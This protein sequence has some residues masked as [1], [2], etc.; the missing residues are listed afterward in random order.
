MLSDD[1]QRFLL[2]RMVCASDRAACKATLL[3]M[4]TVGGWKGHNLNFKAA[5]EVITKDPVAFALHVSR[6]L[7]AKAA[8]EHMALMMH[9]SVRVRQWA[10]ELAYRNNQIGTSKDIKVQ[11]QH[12]FDALKEMA[13]N[14]PYV[15]KDDVYDAEFHHL[16]APRLPEP[17]TDVEAEGH[18]D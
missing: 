5:Y 12:T 15:E 9:P 17:R 8:L 1:Q 7:I 10:I 13:K 2:A 11:V 18:V 6:Y 3:S 14:T 16:D 4:G